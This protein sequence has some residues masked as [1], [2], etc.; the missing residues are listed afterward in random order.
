MFTAERIGREVEVAMYGLKGERK[1]VPLG[2]E[3]NFIS[4]IEKI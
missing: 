3:N 2:L 4:D 1:A